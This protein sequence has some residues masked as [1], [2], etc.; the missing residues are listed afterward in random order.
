MTCGDTQHQRFEAQQREE[1]IAL[2]CGEEAGESLAVLGL[3]GRE[4]GHAPQDVGVE[5]QVVG[6]VVVPV[7]VLHPPAEADPEHQ[8]AVDQA[9]GLDELA[10]PGDLTVSRV[11]HEEGELL[12]PDGEPDR[13]QDHLPPGAAGEGQGRP[14]EGVHQ[15]D[16]RDP[17]HVLARAGPHEPGGLDAPGQFAEV[18]V[19]R[20]RFIR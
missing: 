19:L 6:V 4:D 20:G 11:V 14:A 5:L 1:Q 7:V 15:P 10:G 12:V 13:G 18:L 3:F 2:V 17:G 9:E 16:H 8:V